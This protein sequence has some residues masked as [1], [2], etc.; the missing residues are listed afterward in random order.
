MAQ[1]Q[2]VASR[3]N[4]KQG[5]TMLTQRETIIK[6]LRRGW[7]TGL[8]AVHDCGSLKLASRVSELRREGYAIADKWIEQGGKKF[9]AYRMPRRNAA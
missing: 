2:G 3:R 7:C 8:Q 5:A 6:R 4:R 9:K 1:R